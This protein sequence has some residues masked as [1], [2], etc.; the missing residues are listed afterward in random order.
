MS[1]SKLYRNPDGKFMGVCSGLSDY[2]RIDVGL[3]RLAFIVG[4]FVTGGVAFFIYLALGIF[5]PVSGAES[6]FDK[7][8]SDYWDGTKGQSKTKK[9]GVDINDVKSEFDNLKSRVS[10]MEDSVFNKEKDWD[11]RFKRS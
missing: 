6:V 8:K 3:L 1:G 4:T 7:V 9:R 2:L 11:E 10:K 5:L